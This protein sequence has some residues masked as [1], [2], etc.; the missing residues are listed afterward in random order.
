MSFQEEGLQASCVLQRFAATPVQARKLYLCTGSQTVQGYLAHT[1]QHPPS[2]RF[3][4]GGGIFDLGLMP[5]EKGS[6][7]GFGGPFRLNRIAVSLFGAAS[8]D[9][10]YFPSRAFC[11]GRTD[12]SMGVNGG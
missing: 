2:T 1:K 4:E 8:G 9:K 10:Q 11:L 12:F 7:R 6:P 3:C 5:D